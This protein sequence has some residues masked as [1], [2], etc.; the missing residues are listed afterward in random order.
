MALATRLQQPREDSTPTDITLNLPSLQF[1]SALS[2]NEKELLYLRKQ[3][4]ALSITGCA[5]ATF[6]VTIL[7]EARFEFA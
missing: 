1:E 4:H 2:E 6:L 3:N 5:Q 7:N